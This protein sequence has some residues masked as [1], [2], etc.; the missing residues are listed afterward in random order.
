MA[1]KICFEPF[2]TLFPNWRFVRELPPMT[3]AENDYFVQLVAAAKKRTRERGGIDNVSLSEAR[4]A[5]QRLETIP[6]NSGRNIRVQRP[7]KK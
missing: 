7:R 3:E 2:S 1:E 4:K 5:S 6:P